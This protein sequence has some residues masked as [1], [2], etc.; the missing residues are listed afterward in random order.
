[1]WIAYG[2][3]PLIADVMGLAALQVG[4]A[5]SVVVQRAVDA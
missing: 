2:R 3:E 1:M 4:A 5:S